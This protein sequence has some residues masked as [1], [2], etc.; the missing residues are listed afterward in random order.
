MDLLQYGKN[1]RN[2]FEQK[3]QIP[4]DAAVLISSNSSPVGAC[5]FCLGNES[6]LCAVSST[7]GMPCWCMS[8]CEHWPCSQGT[9]SGWDSVVLGSGWAQAARA[10]SL[11]VPVPPFPARNTWEEGMAQGGM[12][13]TAT[14]EQR[15]VVEGSRSCSTCSSWVGGTTCSCSSALCSLYITNFYSLD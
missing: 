4:V 8:L 12:A 5:L 15:S 3:P 6:D 11:T 14:D 9:D 7:E 10:C 13:A 1:A 2:D